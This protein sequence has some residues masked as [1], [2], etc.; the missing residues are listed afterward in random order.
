MKWRDEVMTIGDNSF[1]V[2]LI[3]S[4]NKSPED[5]VGRQLGGFFSNTMVL[6]RAIKNFGKMTREPR[7]S[8]T[9]I[10]EIQ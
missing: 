3:Q 7:C 6:I 9:L 10:N 2:E 8:P 5:A 4:F 1:H